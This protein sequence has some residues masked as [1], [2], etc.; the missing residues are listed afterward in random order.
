MAEIKQA[1][2]AHLNNNADVFA[3][4]ANRITAEKVPDNQAYPNGRVWLVT[5]PRQYH[6]GGQSGR[7]ATV[8]IDIY[9]ETQAE[10]DDGAEEV[11]V[12]LSG[13]KGMLGDSVDAGYCFV[14]NI[15]GTWNAEARNYHRILEVE[16]GTND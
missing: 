6:H 16:I 4:F 11:M 5:S 8:Q 10:A 12:S 2:I 1:V 14:N 15:S 13:Y 3:T 7:K 9:A